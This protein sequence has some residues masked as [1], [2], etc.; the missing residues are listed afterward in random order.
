MPDVTY[1]QTGRKPVAWQTREKRTPMSSYGWLTSASRFTLDIDGVLIGTFTE[2]SGLSAEIAI[3][4]VEEGG[5]NRY[6]HQ[7]PGRVTWPNIKL[8]RG[9][10]DDDN[11]FAWF[12]RT[13]GFEQVES[14]SLKNQLAKRKINDAGDTRFEG[15]GAL[16]LHS[17]AVTLVNEDGD[18]LRTWIIDRAFP[19]KWTGPTF[20]VASKDVPTEELEIAHH[21]FVARNLAK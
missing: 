13:S 15:A 20:V 14:E 21:G 12:T 7:R 6:V 16:T 3:E 5:E 8:K 10:V 2:I 1:T 11:L 9:V 17:G 18:A 19:V 4:K